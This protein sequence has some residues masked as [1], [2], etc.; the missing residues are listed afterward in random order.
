VDHLEHCA[1]NAVIV[2]DEVQKVM[3]G[4]L[5]VRNQVSIVTCSYPFRVG[6][7]S[8]CNIVRELGLM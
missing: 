1:G 3:P 4:T 5:E 7:T 8:G 6:Q 2:F